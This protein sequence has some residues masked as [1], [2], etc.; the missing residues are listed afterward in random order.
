MA[1]ALSKTLYLSVLYFPLLM[2]DAS[3]ADCRWHGRDTRNAIATHV[4]ALQRTEHE[5]SDR[6]K[7]LDSRPFDFLLGEARKT[8]AIVA[9][10]AA[11]EDEKTLERCRNATRPIRKLCADAGQMLVDILDKHAASEKPEYDRPR[12]ALLMAECAKAMDLKPL[13]SVIRGTG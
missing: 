13:K 5:A 11:L 10:P 9:A 7:G 12:Y 6:I 2:F 1:Y 4:A 8:M 3:A